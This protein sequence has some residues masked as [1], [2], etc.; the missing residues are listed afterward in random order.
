MYKQLNTQLKEN[1]GFLH[2]VNL[3]GLL[4]ESSVTFDGEQWGTYGLDVCVCISG[5]AGVPHLWRFVPHTVTLD[6]DCPGSER[7]APGWPDKMTGGF[8]LLV[9][10]KDAENRSKRDRETQ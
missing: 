10:D 2:N 5:Q 7:W 3:P 4:Q 9:R 8:I 1:K 6:S